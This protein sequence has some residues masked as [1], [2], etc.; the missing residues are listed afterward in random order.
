MKTNH[1]DIVWICKEKKNKRIK[2]WNTSKYWHTGIRNGKYS[3]KFSY[4]N[5]ASQ[6]ADL[7]IMINVES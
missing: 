2:I 3:L 6:Y 4:G 1:K 5:C 7:P